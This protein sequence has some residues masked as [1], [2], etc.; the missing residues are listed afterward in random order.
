MHLHHLPQVGR[1]ATP[2]G[3]APAAPV[4]VTPAICV[5]HGASCAAFMA[6]HGL[7]LA[8]LEA[9]AHELSIRTLRRVLGR[10]A[11]MRTVDVD[12]GLP[13]TWMVGWARLVATHGGLGGENGDG[14]G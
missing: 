7:R 8:L 9:G 5:V 12:R 1:T 14:L 6:A 11:F 3:P 4:P 10:G 2:P 13:W